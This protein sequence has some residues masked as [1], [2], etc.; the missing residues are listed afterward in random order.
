MALLISNIKNVMFSVMKKQRYIDLTWFFIRISFLRKCWFVCIH[1][2]SM[3]KLE[4]DAFWLMGKRVICWFQW[5][6]FYLKHHMSPCTYMLTK[7]I[8]HKWLQRCLN[9]RTKSDWIYLLSYEKWNNEAIKIIKKGWKP[10]ELSMVLNPD[11]SQLSSKIN[12][13]LIFRRGIIWAFSGKPDYY[14]L[15]EKKYLQLTF[16]RPVQ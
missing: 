15:S 4:F 13:N 16:L 3:T 8:L 10:W 14:F 12:T 7:T 5:C 2:C 6:N 1:T 9:S 11:P